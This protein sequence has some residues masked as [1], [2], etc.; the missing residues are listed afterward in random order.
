MPWENKLP[1][2]ISF[3]LK[4]ISDSNSKSELCNLSDTLQANENLIFI[5]MFT[6]FLK[7]KAKQKKP[8]KKMKKA[9]FN[10][11]WGFGL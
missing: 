6:F 3:L 9:L 1:L 7:K 4:S 5:K 8:C 11:N 2:S 10:Q